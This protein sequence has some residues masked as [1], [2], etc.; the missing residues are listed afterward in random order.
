MFQQDIGTSLPDFMA[1]T[2][3]TVMW[4]VKYN[5][6][7]REYLNPHNSLTA[8][9]PMMQLVHTAAVCCKKIQILSKAALE[10]KLLNRQ[11]PTNK[12]LFN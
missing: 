7:L 10:N 6:E 2:Q 4:T 9:V 5:S 1:S 3:E 12:S 11:T 8:A